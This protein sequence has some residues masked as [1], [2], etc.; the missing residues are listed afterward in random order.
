MALSFLC[1][2]IMSNSPWNIVYS[3]SHDDYTHS[4]IFLHY[5]FLCF[6]LQDPIPPQQ[7]SQKIY[8]NLTVD[9]LTVVN[10]TPSSWPDSRLYVYYYCAFSYFSLQDPPPQNSNL[11]NFYTNLTVETLPVVKYFSIVLA[12]QSLLRL[13][14]FNS[15][16]LNTTFVS[17]LPWHITQSYAD[18]PWWW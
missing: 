4:I 18:R 17:K 7:K 1:I 15:Y 6:S 12:R 9:A 2:Q 13:L 16:S 11:N 3:V 14:L 8:A 5:A 10:Y